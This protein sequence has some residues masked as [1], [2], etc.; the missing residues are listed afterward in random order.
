MPHRR[1]IARTLALAL[2]L[3][4]A[5]PVFAGGPGH[6]PG[7]GPEGGMMHPMGGMMGSPVAHKL[8]MALHTLDLTEEEKTAIHG[9][10]EQFHAT[11]QTKLAQLGTAHKALV[12]QILADPVDE[13]AIRSDVATM[14]NVHAD[15]AVAEAYLVKD[16]RSVL[17][18]DQLVQLEKALANIG[19][20]DMPGPGG[21]HDGSRPRHH[22]G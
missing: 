21:P 7:P 4:L 1:M 17:T 16:I 10:F 9:K 11:N 12:D 19:D 8:M 14:A 6:G 20:D 15:V 13:S 2:P 18:S 5:V 3:A 22:G